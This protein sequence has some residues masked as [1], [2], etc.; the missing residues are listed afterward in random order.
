MRPTLPWYAQ[1]PPFLT[2]AICKAAVPDVLALLRHALHSHGLRVAAE[3][4]PAP[5]QPRSP[6][7]AASA[8]TSSS[9]PPAS[10]GT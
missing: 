6:A 4:L 9:S 8:S 10:S 5:A 7:S 1:E 3:D 2:C